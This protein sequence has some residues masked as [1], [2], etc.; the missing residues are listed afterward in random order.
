MTV[1]RRYLQAPATVFHEVKL[2]IAP[3]LIKELFPLSRNAYDLK[4]CYEFKVEDMKTVHY[5]YK[6]L[7]FGGPKLLWKFELIEI[8]SCQ[9]LEEF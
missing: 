1:H 7:S 8:N 5:V 3:N 2:G 4:L 6:S 9:N